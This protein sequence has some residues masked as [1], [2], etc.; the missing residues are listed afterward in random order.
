MLDL[1]AILKP[2]TPI[3]RAM[4]VHPDFIIGANYGK[5]RSGHPEGQ[6]AHHIREVLDNMN[7]LS[8]TSNRRFLRLIAL[9]HDTFKYRVDPTKPKTGNN[10]HGFIAREFAK[11]FITQTEILEIIELHDEAYNSWREGQKRGNWQKAEERARRLISRLN[12][13]LPLYLAFY[14][15]DNRTGDK[16][17]E[18]YLWF[19]KLSKE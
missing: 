7:E 15:C 17:R 18:N 9:P 2:E 11:Q 5:P 4:I 8:N 3:E 6:V 13:S 1:Q 12:S 19:E 16:N 10:H 14:D